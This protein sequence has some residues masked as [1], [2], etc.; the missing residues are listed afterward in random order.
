M[1]KQ[2]LLTQ[3]IHDQQAA[4]RAKDVGIAR[5]VNI[6]E[7]IATDRIVVIT[8][9]R[10]SGKSTLLRQIAQALEHFYYVNFDDERLYN[11]GL[12]D[13]QTLM[14][15]FHKLFPSKYIL[16]DEIQNVAG[17]ERFVRRISDENY[18]AIITGSHAKLL[19]SELATHLTGRYRK[20]ELY[21]FSFTEFLQY[22]KIQT[23]VLTTQ[24]TA[25]IVKAFD[26]Y[27]IDGGFPEFVKYKNIE[28][29]QSTFN[30]IIYK[31]LIVRFGIQ[32]QKAFKDLAIYLFRNFTGEVSYN[33][34]KGITH[35]GNNNTLKD[36]LAYLEQAYLAF[37]IHK[38]DF[39]LKKQM[40]YSKK[41]YVIDNG[42]RNSVSLKISKEQGQL[43]EN[44][45]FI[46]LMRRY[47]EIWFY[48]SKDNFEVDFVVKNDFLQL[49]QVCY[50][51]QNEETMHRET[52][53][54][55][56]AMKELNAQH[57]TIITYNEGDTLHTNGYTISVL[58][59]WKWLIQGQQNM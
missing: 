41:I 10:R 19:N 17:W 7:L 27:L 5:E 20:I 32:S 14:F 3:V 45:I 4:F 16:I 42:M 55:I 13:F 26:T 57:A 49:Y 40:A 2:P 56:A 53:G 28:D 1:I 11:F 44:T 23:L 48:K 34:L 15:E 37:E 36:Y 51:L 6:N 31:D 50:S 59:A 21:P 12:E 38:F 9:I 29:L 25:N 18:K 8:G 35:I 47:K 46:E 43:L 22:S 52:R 58:P 54:L 33:S 24:N 30:D 39:S